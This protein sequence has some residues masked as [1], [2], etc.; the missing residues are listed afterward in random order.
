MPTISETDE[1][2]RTTLAN[3]FLRNVMRIE[4]A[5]ALSDDVAARNLVSGLREILQ[6]CGQVLF[7]GG[8]AESNA[9]SLKRLDQVND[10]L[11]LVDPRTDPTT[12]SKA[13]SDCLSRL[14]TMVADELIFLADTHAADIGW[15]KSGTATMFGALL[16]DI[17]RFSLDMDKFRWK[18]LL[19]EANKATEHIHEAS[20]KQGTASLA[21][22]FDE[23]ANKEDR[24]VLGFRS[25][26]GAIILAVAVGSAWLLTRDG[27]AVTWPGEVA[28]VAA[29]TPFYFCLLYPATGRLSPRG[30]TARQGERCTFEDCSCLHRRTATGRNA[31]VAN[32]TGPP[33]LY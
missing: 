18:S 13:A 17:K 5:V 12:F 19:E 23:F 8:Y 9:F 22:H 1:V 32:R 28:K 31:E 30:V 6:R 15:A 27:G 4:A 26:A 24:L 3:H 14:Q 16:D 7:D 21:E 10:L 33:S 2:I 25:L 20:G 29:T 11:E